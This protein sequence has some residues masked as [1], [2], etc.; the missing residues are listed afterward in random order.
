MSNTW[1]VTFKG[2]ILPGF[3]FQTVANNFTKL[4]NLNDAQ[5]ARL[6]SGKEITLKKEL[7]FAKAQNYQNSF[8][9]R[10]IKIYLINEKKEEPDPFSGLSLEPIETKKNNKND[11]D[12]DDFYTK[13]QNSTSVDNLGGLSLEPR[14]EKKNEYSDNAPPPHSKT[15]ASFS[16]KSNSNPSGAQTAYGSANHRSSFQNQSKDFNEQYYEAPQEPVIEETFYD[17]PAFTTSPDWF[18]YR[19]D[20]RF[21]RVHYLTAIVIYRISFVAFTFFLVLFHELFFLIFPAVIAWAFLS[22]RAVGLR[23][24]DLNQ[25]AWLAIPVFAPDFLSILP[26]IMGKSYSIAFLF[27]LASILIAI[28]LV[29]KAG[30][31]R[32]NHYG[33]PSE[34]DDIHPVLW[35]FIALYV[36]SLFN[37][38]LGTLSSF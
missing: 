17:G 25:S 14:E 36:L 22:I 29:F 33:L 4:L 13:K 11:D 3:D 8:Q 35:F 31:E 19:F 20:G 26:V 23:L 16:T 38:L 5:V 32:E 6:F 1:K 37:N 10:G 18:D 9:K 30:D 21:N 12:L 15:D 7:P 2:E 28:F 24:H 34:A 27:S